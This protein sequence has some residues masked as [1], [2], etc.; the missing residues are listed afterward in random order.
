MKKNWVLGVAVCG[1][2]SVSDAAYG[3]SIKDILNSAA[4]KD[5]VTAVTG[6]KK[7]TVENLAG[8]WTY[9]N[10]GI[11]LEGDNALKNVAASVAASEMEKKLKEYC[12]KVG[13]VEGAFNYTFNSD[14]TFTNVLK[15][16]T[17]KGT[18]SFNADEKTME[19]HYGKIGKSK[20][21]T[22]T[23]HVVL[24]NDELS[25]LFDADKLLD[26]LTKLSAV[27]KNT[28]L[29]TLNKLASQYDGMMLGFELKK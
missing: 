21:T 17:L 13:I 6:G 3:Q 20:L 5:A 10:P 24:S 26:F 12:A 22:M 1:I 14:S 8:T 4:V 9:V 15:G 19:L 29:Q 18:Y 25:L 2:L 16:K 28:T 23:A 27:S 7:L 11:Q